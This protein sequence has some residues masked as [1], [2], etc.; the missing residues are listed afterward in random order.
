MLGDIYLQKLMNMYMQKCVRGCRCENP[1]YTPASK[2]AH[3]KKG[4]NQFMLDLFL[5]MH[6]FKV[7]SINL[8][9]SLKF[10]LDCHVY[11]VFFCIC[12]PLPLFAKCLCTFWTTSL[13]IF[14]AVLLYGTQEEKKEISETVS[15]LGYSRHSRLFL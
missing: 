6:R 2:N 11:V 1:V 9:T 7:V 8:K 14:L 12:K 15:L 4:K 3:S 13:V 10:A 5:W